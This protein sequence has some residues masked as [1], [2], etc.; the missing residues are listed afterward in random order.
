MSRELQHQ[1]EHI[2]VA[3]PSVGR[4]VHI[5]GKAAIVTGLYDA[6]HDMRIDATLFERGSSG[7]PVLA[8]GFGNS[9]GYWIWPPRA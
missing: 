4:I 8:V 9:P 1:G 3:K 6:P 5:D 2:G 7:Q